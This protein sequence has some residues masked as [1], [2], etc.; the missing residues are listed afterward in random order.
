MK[1]VSLSSLSEID[2]HAIWALVDAPQLPTGAN[3]AWSFEGNGIR[4]RAT[5]IRAF[6]ELGMQ[7]TELPNQLKTQA[8][9]PSPVGRWRPAA[10]LPGTPEDA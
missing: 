4:T 2:V 5:F 8:S 3:I 1:L 7:F 9:G 10:R 6:H